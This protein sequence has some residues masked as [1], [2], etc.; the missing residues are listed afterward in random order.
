MDTPQRVATWKNLFQWSAFTLLLEPLRGRA[1]C[2][3]VR[4]LV[5]LFVPLTLYLPFSL[6]QVNLHPTHIS[7]YQLDCAFR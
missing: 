5:I 6:K 3:L 1:I 4:Y 2:D 7:W